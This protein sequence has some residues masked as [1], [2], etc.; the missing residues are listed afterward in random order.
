MIIHH[1]TKRQEFR[2]ELGPYHAVLMYAR[3]GDVLDFYHVYVPDPFRRRG[4]S[5]K[6]L[7]Q[8]FEYAR[9][10]NCRVVP[11]CPFIAKDFLPQFPEYQALVAPGE[12]PFAGGIL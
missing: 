7:I 12:F 6:L 11:S 5:G 3:R 4:I 9:Q 8:A 1:D 2:I 10:E